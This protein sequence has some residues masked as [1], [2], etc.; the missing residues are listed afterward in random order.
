MA[1]GQANGEMLLT[2]LVLAFTAAIASDTFSFP[3]IM[4]AGHTATI[5]LVIASLGAF[6]VYPAVGLSLFL[7]TAVLYFKRN[8]Q[9]TVGSTKSSYGIETI[10]EQPSMEAAPFSNEA[11]QPR[12][13]AQFQETNPANPMLGP[14]Q[15][16]FEPAPYGT[17][18][19]SPV[20]G[21]YPID[22][23]RASSASTPLSYVYRPDPETGSNSFEREGPNLDEKKEAIVYTE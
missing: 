2:I 21:Q 20:E 18:Q 12:E 7:L 23:E 4:A 14:I 16:G 17:E 9:V 1:F 11:S 22:E 6:S 19:G 8:V 3:Y 5:L 10:M 15:E 13:Y